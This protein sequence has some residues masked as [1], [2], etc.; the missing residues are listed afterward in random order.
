MRWLLLISIVL[1]L[2]FL[3]AFT[4]SVSVNAYE[5][6]PSLECQ[7]LQRS[8]S[9][10]IYTYEQKR[11]TFYNIIQDPDETEGSYMYSL[12]PEETIDGH[13]PVV[14]LESMAG[15]ESTFLQY[16]SND[17]TIT[18][19][20]ING[21]CD[22]GL[23]QI[24]NVTVPLSA[25][26]SYRS[27]TKGNIAAGANVLADK[28]NLQYNVPPANTL[29]VANYFDPEPLFNWYYPIAAYNSGPSANWPNNP[30]CRQN[31]PFCGDVD[32]SARRPRYNAPPFDALEL[33]K[34][35]PLLL[36]YQERVL[37]NL[38]YSSVP[39]EGPWAVRG[40]KLAPFTH[41]YQT[42]I[43]PDDSLFIT[44]ENTSRAP[45]LLLFQ[46]TAYVHTPMGKNITF[47]YDLPLQAE[48]VLTIH[49]SDG[50]LKAIVYDGLSEAG[51]THHVWNS[52]SVRVVQGDY[53]QIQATANNE[54]GGIF[55]GLYKQIFTVPDL[56]ST[57][58]VYLPYIKAPKN[59]VYNGNFL[60]P[61]YTVDMFD[62]THITSINAVSTNPYYPEYWHIQ[63]I[64]NRNHTPTQKFADVVFIDRGFP[65][66]F[67]TKYAPLDYTEL[68][69]YINLPRVSTSEISYE[70]QFYLNNVFAKQSRSKLEVRYR[71]IREDHWHTLQR[72]N[73]HPPDS[74]TLILPDLQDEAIILSF[75]IQFDQQLSREASLVGNI[76]LIER[77]KGCVPGQP[78]K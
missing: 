16:D 34:S 14:V 39:D 22:Y 75:V 55:E 44:E 4:S 58:P 65:V 13:I 57:Y 10:N 62:P 77:F 8:P 42:G 24:N 48:V 5:Q 66:L 51:I 76:R 25:E 30:G 43:L 31:I 68:R 28:W 38:V 2:I 19:S 26:P 71:R 59:L 52:T 78:C 69:Q 27:T 29:P 45:N 7:P 60:Q 12:E 32:Y 72:Y 6:Q 37:Y 23:M 49:R 21:T 54:Y 40:L 11:N 15:I 73:A 64:S 67:V 53:Y 41:E 1:I 74:E 35:N 46:H 50:L 18:G 61:A 33:V 63:S 47:W 36:P 56:S 3:S 20:N 70:L 9:D 17:L